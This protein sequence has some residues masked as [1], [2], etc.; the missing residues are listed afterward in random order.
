MFTSRTSPRT[1]ARRVRIGA[2]LASA[3]LVAGVLP[4]SV[5]LAGAP[6]EDPTLAVFEIYYRGKP[7]AKTAEYAAKVEQRI[8]KEG[9]F[10]VINKIDAEKLVYAKYPKSE[11]VTLEESADAVKKIVDD[12]TTIFFEQGAGP[13]LEKLRDAR[14]KLQRIVDSMSLSE[15][16]KKGYIDTQMLLTLI[17]LKSNS[18]DKAEEVMRALVRQVG[19]DASINTDNYHPDAVALYRETYRK[20]S[21]QRVG[22]ISVRSNPPGADVYINGIKQDKTTPAVFEGL[23]P[24][25]V[26]IQVKK[27]ERSSHMR[28]INVETGTV[29]EFDVDLAFESAL[30][31]GN[32]R[33]GLEFLDE[34]DR[35]RN[36]GPFAAK[37]GELVGVD[38]VA[39]VGL[40]DDK[41]E[42]KLEGH[43]VQTESDK[44]L[45]GT[46]MDANANVV[47]KRRIGE[48]A[49]YIMYGI[50]EFG[51]N[52]LPW[53]ENTKGW[54]LTGVG[55]VA[56][57][58]GGLSYAMYSSDRKDAECNPNTT[59]CALDEAGRQDAKKSAETERTLAYTGF[60]VGAAALVGGILIFALDN[61]EDPDAEVK[62]VLPGTGIKTTS[63]QPIFTPQGD[64][65]LGATFTF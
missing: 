42:T 32:G 40:G 51:T 56:G 55:V 9:G 30:A 43:L 47:S 34:L 23:F 46:G 44:V 5:A 26:R 21:E 33:Y 48:M 38:Y 52:Y 64:V 39:V 50:T 17:Y 49:Y 19:Q 8:V 10:D 15:E 41:G 61:E 1:P 28:T 35:K 20:M 58:L 29:H 36:L 59:T 6:A 54:I 14:E 53:Y 62:P 60:G 12:A 7:A 22:Q 45:R 63:I 2:L 24:G 11:D 27:G 18:Q 16:L 37:L 3:A 31:F 13:A 57:G 25:E 4:S 65:G